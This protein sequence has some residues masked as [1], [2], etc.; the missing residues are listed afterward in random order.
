MKTRFETV[1]REQFYRDWQKV[2]GIQPEDEAAQRDWAYASLK[3]P[4]RATKKSAGYDFFAPFDISIGPGET[5]VIPSGIRAILRDDQV[6]IIAPRSSLGFKYRLQ[7]D[8]SI[9]VI[10]ADYYVSDNEG[11]IMLKIT[12]DSRDYRPCFIRTG[13][14]LVQGI[15][16]HYETMDEEDEPTKERNGGIG[17]TNA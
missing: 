5:V 14:A 13:D 2:F 11:H 17:S 12:N 1:S 16:L 4:K 10:D 7:L 15:I 6:M 8:N 9:G 3:I